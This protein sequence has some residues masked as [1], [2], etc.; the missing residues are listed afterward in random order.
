MVCSLEMRNNFSILGL[1]VAMGA[2]GGG[3]RIGERDV[4][5]MPRMREPGEKRQRAPRKG[6]TASHGAIWRGASNPK[7]DAANLRAAQ[8]NY[9]GWCGRAESGTLIA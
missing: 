1:L 6:D 8:M 5:V 4:K 9:K 3:S 7:R 2:I